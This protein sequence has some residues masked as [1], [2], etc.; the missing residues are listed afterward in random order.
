LFHGLPSYYSN[1]HYDQ[2][3]PRLGVA[4]QLS[5]KMVLRAGGGR[6]YS[7]LG[8]SDSIFLGGNS[9]FQPTASVSNGI[10][11]NPGGATQNIFPLTLTN[12]DRIYKNPESFLWNTMIE[13]QTPW[14]TVLT[15]GYVGRRGLHGQRERDVNQLQ[16]GTLQANAGINPDYLRPYKGYAVLRT[17][18][19]DANSMYNS[20]QINWTKR[21]AHGV[22]FG[23]AYTLS[24]SNDDGSNQRDI[25]P[26]AY[27]AHSLWGPSEF[28]TRHVLIVNYIWDI[29][30]FRDHSKLS[31]K[32]LGGW[33]LSGVTQ[34]QTGTPCGVGTNDDFAGAGSLGSFGC[35]SE[36]QF[37][38]VNGNPTIKGQFAKTSND[39]ALWFATTNPDGTPIFTAPKAGTFNQQSVRDLI[40]GPGLQNWNLS[41]FKKF[42]ITETSGFEFRADA[43]NFVNHP[44]LAAIGH[45]GGLDLNPK[46]GAFGKV[47]G[48]ESERNLQLSLRFYF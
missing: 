48:K 42:L 1:I 45:S 27:N 28:D 6:Y 7:R 26:D 32:L 17:T 30:L 15:V 22:G 21:F 34:F 19:N 39:P 40:Y 9:P 11:D 23:V 12:Q 36:G 41:L 3:Q 25:I 10:V 20:F 46:D 4:W 18:N 2:I 16:S 38:N 14:D 35:G 31:G 13:R 29:P 37:W 43:F 8:V 5:D 24:A 33:Q 44:N 47:T